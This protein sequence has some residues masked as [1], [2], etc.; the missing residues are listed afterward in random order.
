MVGTRVWGRQALL[1]GV[2]T[3]AVLVLPQNAVAACSGTTTVDCTGTISTTGNNEPAAA[4]QSFGSG[5]GNANNFSGAAF[6]GAGTAS[7]SVSLRVTAPANLSTSGANSE[8]AIARSVGGSGGTGDS[9]NAASG[10]GLGAAAGDVTI[11]FNGVVVST[12]DGS[13]G[14]RALSQGG[15]GGGAINFNASA[16]AGA[17]GDAGGVELAVSGTISTSGL[18]SV[19]VLAESIG[20]HG[21]RAESFNAGAI[22]GAGGDGQNVIVSSSADITTTGDGSHGL[23]ARSLRGSGGGASSFNGGSSGGASGAGGSVSVA[24]SGDILTSGAGSRAIEAIANGGSV[25]VEVLDGVLTG[26]TGG[27]IGVV[28]EAA[29]AAVFSN[30]GSIEAGSGDALRISGSDIEVSNYGSISGDVRLSNDSGAIFSNFAGAAL[31]SGSTFDLGGGTLTN[32]G[33]LSPGGTGRIETTLLTGSYAQVGAISLNTAQ[34]S[35]PQNGAALAV[36]TLFV[37][38]DWETGHSDRLDIT[39]SAELNGKVIVNALALPD[40]EDRA[41]KGLTK[42]FTILTATEGVTDYGISVTDT[43][44]VDFELLFPDVNTVDLQATINFLGN[45]EV[46]TAALTSNQKNVGTALNQIVGDGGDPGFVPDLLALGTQAEL[47]AAL[48]QL[49]PAGDAAQ[50][51]SAMNTG[52]TFAGQLLSCRTLGEGNP[53]AFIREGQCLWVRANVRQLDNDG[54]NGETGFNETATFYSAGAQFDVGGP[55]RVGAGIGF[56]D[57]DVRTRS[58]A[59]SETERLHLGAV[60]KYNPGPLLLAASLTGGYGWSD[61]ARFVSFGGFTDLATSESEQS[62]VSGRL[63]GAYLLSRGHWYAKP[64]IDLAWTYLDRD[65]FTEA[66]S[67]G[68]ALTVAGNDDTVFSISPSI[69]FGAEY[70]LAFGGVARPYVKGGVTWLDT[71]SF[72]TSATFAGVGPGAPGFEIGTTIDDL[73]ADLGLGIDFLAE[74]GTVLRVQYDAQFGEQT[75]NHSGSAKLSVPF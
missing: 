49:T 28:I 32:Y 39:G 59:Q 52:A 50:F 46:A 35:G 34:A 57:G 16:T 72:V 2:A 38:A 64:Q 71:D 26:G 12:A 63:T 75:E 15:Q 56:E 73:V 36:G 40:A 55:W 1:A 31:I 13:A 30:A 60:V 44:A 4:A 21:G 9:F 53:N 7:S 14:L 51:A 37:D 70:P 20:G 10:G 29:T 24:T 5:G 65:G 22:G 33:T 6:G 11:E 45:D 19:G 48:D 69:E 67:G 18:T 66:S 62:F 47:G 27:G 61:N 41:N 58:N 25:T 3:C 23:V 54:R 74:S 42:S 8:G 43:A 68:S 17:G